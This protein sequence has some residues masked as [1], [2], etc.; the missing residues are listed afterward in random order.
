LENF[1][2]NTK[3]RLLIHAD[4]GEAGKE[5]QTKKLKTVVGDVQSI[6]GCENIEPFFVTRSGEI[7]KLCVKHNKCFVKLKNTQIMCSHT[8]KLSDKNFLTEL[9]P[10]SKGIFENISENTIPKTKIFIGSSTPGF[11]YA[12]AVKKI[13]DEDTDYEG[14]VW[15]DVFGDDN[16]TTIEKI[17]NIIELFKYSILV[18]SPDDI[19]KAT[20]NKSKQKIPRDNV[21]FEYGLFMGKN[22][23]SNTFLM[24]PQSRDN[25]PLVHILTDIKGLNY[26]PYTYSGSGETNIKSDVRNACDD[27]IGAIR[28]KN[29]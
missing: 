25:E 22:G 24:I 27:I 7:E 19:V 5:E 18:F 14:V 6:S 2:N 11:E 1:P 28:K 23:R 8:S 9:N 10:F 15:K 12:K 16:A 26:K 3:F 17:E 20:N 13:V 21:I 4:I 29:N